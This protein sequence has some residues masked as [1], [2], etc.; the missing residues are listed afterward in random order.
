MEKRLGINGGRTRTRTWDPLIKSQLLYQLSYAPG[1]RPAGRAGGVL[2]QSEFPLSREGPK[3]TDF[4]DGFARPREPR[5]R[6]SA[7]TLS[8]RCELPDFASLIRAT[9]E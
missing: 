9:S 6:M 8:C 2:Y 5:S 1:N 7:A 3:H 4:R